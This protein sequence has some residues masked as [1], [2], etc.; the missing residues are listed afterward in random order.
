MGKHILIVDDES[1][2]CFALQR[3][4][5][6][7][8]YKVSVAMNGKDGMEIIRR[9]IGSGERMDLAIVDIQIPQLSGRR[10][11]SDLKK[12]AIPVSVFIVSGTNDKLF[13]I[14]LLEVCGIESFERAWPVIRSEQR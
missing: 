4:L 2:T 5:V 9:S 7:Y 3:A 12:E 8:G 14:N 10:L 1:S 13:L 6:K 11:I